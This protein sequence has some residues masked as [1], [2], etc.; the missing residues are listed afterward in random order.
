MEE[1]RAIKP[2]EVNYR[3]ESCKSGYMIYKNTVDQEE[4]VN[5]YIHECSNC[6]EIASFYN[7]QYPYIEWKPLK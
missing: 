6:N 2:I 3:C 7:S 1:R 4:M 5:L